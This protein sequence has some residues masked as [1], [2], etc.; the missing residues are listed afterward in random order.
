VSSRPPLALDAP[1]TRE[2]QREQPEQLGR[3]T[4]T[5]ALAARHDGLPILASMSALGHYMHETSRAGLH[6]AD[7]LHEGNGNLWEAA[8]RS[9]SRHV[10]WILIEERAEGGDVLAA[11]A[12]RDLNFLAGFDRV[13]EGGGA[14]LY[15]RK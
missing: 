6:L 15:R 10:G 14:A 4:V 13:A 9:P 1:V 8:I 11:L 2:A 12:R 3:G 5:A 7:Y